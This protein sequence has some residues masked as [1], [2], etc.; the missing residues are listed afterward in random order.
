MISD[1]LIILL[2][3]SR[4]LMFGCQV[5]FRFGQLSLFFVFAKV[6]WSKN[7]NFAV[8]HFNYTLRKIYPKVVS[9]G[10]M[11]GS[12]VKLYIAVVE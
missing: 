3:S 12:W 8:I 4:D 11:V 1:A 6:I 5:S 9:K 7:I 2:F 10:N